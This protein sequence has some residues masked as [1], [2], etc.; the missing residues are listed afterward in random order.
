[1]LTFFIQSRGKYSTLEQ[2][3]KVRET[4]LAKGFRTSLAAQYAPKFHDAAR[5]CY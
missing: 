1:M 3:K 4:L 5:D 2:D